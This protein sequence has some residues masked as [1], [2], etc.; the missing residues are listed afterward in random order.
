MPRPLRHPCAGPPATAGVLGVIAALILAAASLAAAP[1]EPA[2]PAEPGAIEHFERRIRPLLHRHCYECHSG[3]AKVVQGGLRLDRRDLL[4]AGGDSGPAVIPGKPAESLLVASLAHAG[5]GLDMPPQGRLPAAE[6]DLVADWIARGAAMPDDG[7]SGAAG[8]APDIEGSRDF[9]SFRPLS[10][11]PPPAIDDPWIRTPVDAFVLAALRERG[12]APAPEADRATLLRRLSFDLVGL[13]P[14]PEEVDAFVTDPS[15]GAFDAAV[16]RL[17]ASPHHG[18][19][20]GRMWLDLARY[21]DTTESWLG[22]TAGAWYYRDWVVRAFNDDVPYDRFVRRQLAT[23]HLA[24][25]GPDDLAALGFLGLSPTYFKELQLPP[26]IIKVIVAD[27]W[28]ERVDA[29]GRTFLGLSLACAR[30]HD[31]KFD[32]VTQDDYYALAGVFASTRMADRPMIPADDYRPVAAAKEEVVR[33]EAELAKAKKQKPPVA[34]TIADLEAKI[35]AVKAATPLYDTPL[36]SA[37]IDEALDVV[38]AGD[39]PQSG[40]R[41]AWR[42]GAQDLPVHVR[43]NPN[44]PGRVVPRRFL[45]VLSRGEPRPLSTGSGR[46][47]LADAILT[48]AGPLAARVIVNRIWLGHFGRG[49]VETPSNFGPMGA[50][51]SHPA[52]LEHL[53]AGFVEHGWSLKWLHR[54]IVGSAAWRQSSRFDAAAH[55]HDPD[56]RLLWRAHRRRL[57]IEPWRD[58][59]LAVT[60]ELAPSIGGPPLAADD[61]ANLRRTIYT[62]VHRREPATMLLLHDFPDPSLHAERRL[63]TTTPLQGLFTLNSPFVAARAAALA[64]RLAREVPDDALA[65]VHRAH[66]LLFGRRAREDE[67]WAAAEFLTASRAGGDAVA[68]AE[69]AWQAYAHALLGSN[70][71]LFVD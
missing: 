53:A 22:S 1:A 38:L 13:P 16:E 14:T 45:T 7:G 70:E 47:D 42:T 4:L 58:A 68:S 48:E 55:A 2:T 40:T 5:D 12:L 11:P 28:E 71:F 18:E 44:R 49:L 67:L 23:D 35:A 43:G 31:H 17:L 25:T 6:I 60:G 9:W 29:V 24:D 62:T 57:E 41:L 46:A 33:L 52:L 39:D 37:V 64:A 19:R 27:E 21:T 66:G 56:N 15:S 50:P 51:P 20:W 34:E 61:P 36:V 8:A 59:M 69:A 30:C 32:P 26:D 10:A 3:E 65:R 54:Q 63:E